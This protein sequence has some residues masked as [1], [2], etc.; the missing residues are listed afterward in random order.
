M[1][2][3]K[4][5]NKQTNKKW[6]ALSD[7]RPTISIKCKNRPCW[8][9]SVCLSWLSFQSYTNEVRLIIDEIIQKIQSNKPCVD[10]V[11]LVILVWAIIL[12]IFA[13]VLRYPCHQR[14]EAAFWQ[15]APFPPSVNHSL[16]QSWQVSTSP[17]W[18]DSQQQN[19]NLMEYCSNMSSCFPNV[20]FTHFKRKMQPIGEYFL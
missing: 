18:L 2:K 3:K 9:C 7:P 17:V 20:I 5:T 13:S 16:I 15:P 8:P 19:M 12:F 10:W 4:Q 14:T 11:I 6:I 1:E